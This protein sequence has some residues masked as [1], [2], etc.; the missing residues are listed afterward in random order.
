MSNLKIKDIALVPYFARFLEGQYSA[1][2]TAEEMQAVKGGNAFTQAYPS[3][4]EGAADGGI[5]ESISEWIQQALHGRPS[6]PL[7]GIPMYP[8]LPGSE[9]VTNAYPSDSDIVEVG[10]Y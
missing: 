3:D 6:L 4:Q 1:E 8:S 7:Q 2:M 9:M 10:D 5:D